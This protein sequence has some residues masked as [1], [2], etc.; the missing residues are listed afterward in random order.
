MI[1]EMVITMLKDS[2]LS[3]M[4]WDQVVHTIVHNLNRG[5]LRSNSDKNPYELWKGILENVKNFRVFGSKC[6]IKREDVRLEKF[7]SRVDKGILVGYSRK[8]KAYK[9]FSPRINRIMESINVRIDD[10][11]VLNLHIIDLD[12]K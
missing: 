1:Q 8:I 2:K 10:V 3:D 6:Y 12:R 7:E 5:M 11:N 4:F 9:C